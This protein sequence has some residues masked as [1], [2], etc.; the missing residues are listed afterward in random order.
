MSIKTSLHLILSTKSLQMA[1]LVSETTCQRT[2]LG[3]GD[4]HPHFRSLIIL[5]WV[6]HNTA[7]HCQTSLTCLASWREMMRV[8][9]WD[10]MMQPGDYFPRSWS[11][12]LVSVLRYIIVTIVTS[13]HGRAVVTRADYSRHQHQASHCMSQ[14]SAGLPS[15]WQQTILIFIFKHTLCISSTLPVCREE[16]ECQTL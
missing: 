11:Q 3:F 9:I 1:S 4:K 10:V 6:L 15:G 7:K 8:E 12:Q 2:S 13:S 16:I 14:P 5:L